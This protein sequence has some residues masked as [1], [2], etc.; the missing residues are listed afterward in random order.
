MAAEFDGIVCHLTDRIDAAV[1]ESGRSGNAPRRGKRGRRLRQHRRRRRQPPWGSRVC[2][3][4]GVLDD[5][6]A[7]LAF[8]LILTATRLAS[9]A[10]RDLREGRWTGWGFGTHLARDVHGATLGLVGFGRIAR[11]VAQRAAGFD[12]EV[13]HTARHDTEMSGFV[14]TLDELLERSDIVSLHVPLSESTRHL[15]GAAELARM[16]PTAVLINTARGPVVDEDALVDALESGS[17]YSRRPRRLRRG[18]RG[19]SPDPHCAPDDT[20]SSHRECNYRHAH[21]HG[22]ARMPRR[23]ATSWRGGRRP[24][25]SFPRH[26]PRSTRPF[27]ATGSQIAVSGD[28]LWVRSDRQFGRVSNDTGVDVAHGP[29]ST[30]MALSAVLAVALIGILGSQ[31][32]SAPA[33]AVSPQWQTTAAFNPLANVSAVSCAPSA[34][35]SSATCVAVGDDGG[36]WPPSSSPTTAAQPGPVQL[37]PSGVTGLTTVSCP[38]ACRLLRR[39]RIRIAE[40]EQRRHDVDGSGLVVPGSI[41]LL[42]HDRRMHG[43][44]RKQIS[45]RRRWVYL[46]SSDSTSSRPTYSQRVSCPNAITCVAIGIVERQSLDRW[47]DKWE[48][49]GQRLAQPAVVSSLQ[50]SCFTA[51]TCVAVGIAQAGGA[52]SLARQPI[53]RRGSLTS[54][55]PSG[56]QL[57]V[58]RLPHRNARASPSAPTSAPPRTSSAPRTADPLGRPEPPANAVDLTGISCSA[59]ERLHCRR[60]QRQS[61]SWFDDHVHDRRRSLV[62]SADP[63]GG[64]ESAEF[65]LVPDHR[66]LLRR[67]CEL[68]S[69]FGQ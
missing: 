35:A 59:A 53:L 14:P 9:D 49:V 7:D 12:M 63:A 42:L 16:K 62:D 67:R 54:S 68:G 40:V 39:R 46:D 32:A 1:L 52:T 38:S 56:T 17:I 27:P 5:T 4:P 66:R 10:E 8:L 37:P 25:S 48:R 43:G 33:D 45:S 60:R 15:I 23:C 26:S 28:C 18:A 58:D 6:T 13:I 19:E 34:T 24:T 47:D 65:G 22:A 2:N 20:A 50:L 51:T 64:H 3:T 61:W 29:E 21:A 44:R 57:E 11:A 36:K 31:L 55:I 69:R 30:V 41:D